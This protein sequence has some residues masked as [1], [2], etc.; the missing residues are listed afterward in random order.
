MVITDLL[1]QPPELKRL[2]SITGAVDHLHVEIEIGDVEVILVIVGLSGT[3]EEARWGVDAEELMTADGD[4]VEA[5]LLMADQVPIGGERQVAAKESCIHMAIDGHLG[6]A[7]KHGIEGVLVIDSALERRTHGIDHEG[8]ARGV[9]RLLQFLG[10]H[11]SHGVALDQAHLKV[12]EI[13]ETH[14]RV[15]RLV[16]DIDHGALAGLVIEVVGAKINTMVVAVRTAMGHDTP[17]AVF[18]KAVEGREILNDIALKCLGRHLPRLVRHWVAGVVEVN[19][20]H[21][22][23]EVPFIE[24]VQGRLLVGGIAEIGLL[25]VF[26]DFRPLVQ[27]LITGGLGKTHRAHRGCNERHQ[28]HCYF[29]HIG[30]L[31]GFISELIV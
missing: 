14:V 29:S 18:G 23:R 30:S 6:M 15:M 19:D 11:T 22:R 10:N 3:E 4:G 20:V 25:T 31:L 21:P 26:P 12:L 1:D 16:G 5:H 13:A 7:V 8:R 24:L 2:D 28:N 17:D 9:E 27:F